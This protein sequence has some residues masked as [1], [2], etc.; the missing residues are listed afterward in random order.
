MR[1]VLPTHALIAFSA[2]PSRWRSSEQEPLMFTNNFGHG[3][4]P[5]F[6][7]IRLACVPRL[8]GLRGGVRAVRRRMHEVRRRTLLQGVRGSLQEMPRRVP[9][10]A[11]VS[12]V[13]TQPSQSTRASGTCGYE[14]IR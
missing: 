11:A 9:G 5:A 3:F 2:T 14:R 10:D 7:M 4:T 8:R 1:A 12:S 6:S 13:G